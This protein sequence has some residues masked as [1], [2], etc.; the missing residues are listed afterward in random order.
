MTS[1]V[2][3][4]KSRWTSL[5]VCK[6]A[7]PVV[8]SLILAGVGWKISERVELF[9]S[10]VASDAKAVD[11]LMQKRL[12]LYDDIGR[13]L[14]RLFAYYMYIGKWKELSPDDIIM[15]KRE[16]DETVFTYQP[17]L[18]KEFIGSYLAL[19]EQLF[20]PF[21]SWGTDAMLRTGVAYRKDFYRPLNG[22]PIWNTA[23]SDRFTNEDNTAAIRAAY[24]SLISQ[25]PAEVGIPKALWPARTIHEGEVA[26]PNLPPKS[27]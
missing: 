6:L 26:K 10:S 16:L 12:A 4:E 2:S 5:E 11:S 24:S 14:N 3:E 27:Q 21:N 23:W 9:R 22:E 17:L 7:A 25:L 15:H 19:N 20:R 8:A 18:S 13:K 1:K